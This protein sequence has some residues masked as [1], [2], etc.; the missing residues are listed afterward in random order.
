MPTRFEEKKQKILAQLSTP[1]DAYS[2]LS[3]KG[4]VDEGV[5]ELCDEINALDGF[6]TTSSCAGRIAVYLEGRQSKVSAEE[7]VGEDEQDAA[8]PAASSGGK[9]GGEW[10][11]V[12]HD[13]M[14]SETI[15]NAK[16][17]GGLL[18]LFGIDSDEK[19]S[20][21]SNLDGIRFVHFRFEPMV[22]RTQYIHARLTTSFDLFSF[23]TYHVRSRPTSS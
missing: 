13:P 23:S 15:S 22:S 5:R 3:P 20:S 21:P 14:S 11:Y 9:G 8:R 16:S 1:E 10:F 19:P 6:V 4:S 12:S 18:K 2:D 17:T 7:E